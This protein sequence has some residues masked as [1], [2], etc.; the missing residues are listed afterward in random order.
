M[1][2]EEEKRD[3]P[4]RIDETKLPVTYKVEK[5]SPFRSLAKTI[6]WRIIATLTTFLISWL[7]TEDYG[8]ALAIGGIEAVLKLVAYYFH[9]RAWTNVKWGKT[10]NKNQLVRA[11]KLRYLIYL[12]AK[13]ARKR[14]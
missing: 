3:N 2:V 13:Q 8:L 12:R 6:S 11:L 9:E 7:I 10:W 14:A 5:D 4:L 1:S